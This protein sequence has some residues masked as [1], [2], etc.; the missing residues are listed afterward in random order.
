MG[1]NKMSK[2]NGHKNVHKSN[3]HKQEVHK[4]MCI[5]KMQIKKLFAKRLI[6]VCKKVTK[7]THNY[8]QASKSGAL[9]TNY[10][11]HHRPPQCGPGPLKPRWTVATTAGGG[12]PSQQVV[13][14]RQPLAP[15]CQ[16]SGW[17]WFYNSQFIASSLCS[18]SSTHFC[19]MHKLSA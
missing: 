9:P 16:E 19:A 17:K 1:I 15:P 18:V 7:A 12:R 11:H 8:H 10:H 4:K 5:N 2:T 13:K 6:P 3:V 14:W